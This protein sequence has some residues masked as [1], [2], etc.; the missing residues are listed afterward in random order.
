MVA[1]AVVVLHQGLD[2]THTLQRAVERIFGTLVGL[3]LAGLVLT[4]RLQGVWLVVIL[5]GLQFI[6][7]MLVVRNYAFAVVFMTAAA[8]IIASGGETVPD[9]GDLLSARGLDTLIGCLV[10]LG[11]HILT[12]LRR[13]AVPVPQQIIGTL[14]ALEAVLGFLANNE[15]TSV[16]AKRARRKGE[17]GVTVV[18]A[19]RFIPDK[20]RECA[21]ETDCASSEILRH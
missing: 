21:R 15:V 18:F 13:A 4:L 14:A 20:A 2:W 3:A 9:L 8:L 7:E 1:A 17:R 11:V 6:I 10:G 5:A 19:D 12:A 16:A